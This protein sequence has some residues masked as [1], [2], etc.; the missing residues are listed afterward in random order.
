MNYEVMVRTI[1]EIQ[2]EIIQELWVR[3]KRRLSLSRVAEWRLLTYIPAVAIHVFELILDAFKRETE[4]NIKRITAGT[5]RWYAWMGRQFQNGHELLF[6][7]S[8]GKLY[9]ATEDE[10]ARIIKMIAVREVE[11]KLLIKAAKLSSEGKIIPLS[12]DELSNFKLYVDAI[13]FAGISVSVVSITEDKIKYNLQV[14]VDT[15]VRA[16]EIKK[17]IE[18]ALNRFKTTISFDSVFY[19]Q[20]LINAVMGVPGVVTCSLISLKRKGVSDA[21]FTDIPLCSELEAGYF[22]YDPDCTLE[23][24]SIKEIAL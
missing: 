20:Q 7:E 16:T 11:N 19:R 24:K 8:S 17:E 10:T 5:P 13:S 21:E 15:G 18:A 12:N 4:E 9:Y 22:E 14:F 3:S 2:G 6:D 23:I 1:E